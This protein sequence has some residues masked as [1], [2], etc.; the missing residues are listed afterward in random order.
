MTKRAL[1]AIVNKMI[2]RKLQSELGGKLSEETSKL[3]FKEISKLSDKTLLMQLFQNVTM[4]KTVKETR[5]KVSNLLIKKIMEDKLMIKNITEEVAEKISK[6]TTANITEIVTKNSVEKAISKSN[7]IIMKK[8]LKKVTEKVA[9]KT[10]KLAVKTTIVSAVNT[11]PLVGQVAGFLINAVFASVDLIQ[12]ILDREKKIANL[13]ETITNINKAKTSLNSIKTDLSLAKQS[14]SDII[15]IDTVLSETDSSIS[16]DMRFILDMTIDKITMIKQRVNE[17]TCYNICDSSIFIT[18]QNNFTASKNIITKSSEIYNLAYT[19]N[20]GLDL[21]TNLSDTTA[22]RNLLLKQRNDNGNGSLV[23]IRTKLSSLLVYYEAIYREPLPLLFHYDYKHYRQIAIWS[24][25]QKTTAKHYDEYLSSFPTSD[26][27]VRN[28]LYFLRSPSS[29]SHYRYFYSPYYYNDSYLWYNQGEISNMYYVKPLHYTTWAIIKSLLHL[30]RKIELLIANTDSVNAN[31]PNLFNKLYYGIQMVT[32]FSIADHSLLST[33]MK[34]TYNSSSLTSSYRYKMYRYIFNKTLN[35]FKSVNSIGT[36]A[37]DGS[38]Y[39]YDETNKVFY[40]LS[41]PDV[42]SLAYY[43]GSYYKVTASTGD[44]K[45][46][47]ELYTKHTNVEKDSTTFIT[48][49]SNNKTS[50]I[51]TIYQNDIET[52]CAID[53]VKYDIYYYTNDPPSNPTKAVNLN[54]NSKYLSI[55]QT[56]TGIIYFTAINNNNS[57]K[58]LCEKNNEDWY[59]VNS[60]N[61]Q[62]SNVICETTCNFILYHNNELYGLED[63]GLKLYKQNKTTKKL[64]TFVISLGSISLYPINFGV[65]NADINPYHF[66][67]GISALSTGNMD[68]KT[69]VN[70]YDYYLYK[71]H[72]NINIINTDIVDTEYGI[73]KNLAKKIHGKDSP[74][75]TLLT[76]LLDNV[77]V[78]G[79][80]IN[81]RDNSLTEDNIYI[82]VLEDNVERFSIT[83]ITLSGLSQNK[84]N[85]IFF[86]EK[87]KIILKN[88]NVDI[89]GNP[90]IQLEF[91]IDTIYSSEEIE[92]F[93]YTI[94][95]TLTRTTMSFESST[96]DIIHEMDFIDIFLLEVYIKN[97][98]NKSVSETYN[99]TQKSISTPTI[100]Y[101][102]YLSNEL[103]EDVINIKVK[104]KGVKNKKFFLSYSPIPNTYTLSNTYSTN[105]YTSSALSYSN[106]INVSGPIK[107]LFNTIF[108]KVYFNSIT[109]YKNGDIKFNDDDSSTFKLNDTIRNNNSLKISYS[110]LVTGST[111]KI[112]VVY[113]TNNTNICQAIFNE[114]QEKF[115]VISLTSSPIV[116][117]WTSFRKIC[118]YT[119]TSM[120]NSVDITPIINISND[121]Y[122]FIENASDFSVTI[123]LTRFNTNYTLYINEISQNWISTNVDNISLRSPDYPISVF[124]IPNKMNGITGLTKINPDNYNSI[125][126]FP[127]T[128]IVGPS[129]SSGAIVPVIDY[130]GIKYDKISLSSD[131]SLVAFGRNSQNINIKP[132]T[133]DNPTLPKILLGSNNTISG[134][135]GPLLNIDSNYYT[136]TISGP[137]GSSIYIVRYEEY[138]NRDYTQLLPVALISDHTQYPYKC[139]NSSYSSIQH[140]PYKCFNQIKGKTE[141]DNAGWRSKKNDYVSNN[142]FEAGLNTGSTIVSGMTI[143]GEWVEL[144]NIETQFAN[145]KEVVLYASSTLVNLR[146]PKRIMVCGSNDRIT[147]TKMLDSNELL[148]GPMNYTEGA[149]H[150][151]NSERLLINH[152]TNYKNIRLIVMQI[153]GAENPALL[154]IEYK[155]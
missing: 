106:P 5:E 51:C 120:T 45:Q 44:I 122:F 49:P 137:S 96:K 6:K 153:R 116:F 108:D 21:S 123:P 91:T 27:G 126:N 114:N 22:F 38:A 70:I 55:T 117:Y 64:D 58:Y 85:L 43:R 155:K 148:N 10:T 149:E 8:A 100:T 125:S 109:I 23:T 1:K 37:A 107:V 76:Q 115:T 139:F 110:I 145:I 142:N 97:P 67:I 69:L 104:F 39:V 28:L 128:G 143:I 20:V 140:M 135:Y 152:S 134:P 98:I 34:I 78:N 127:F 84:L 30:A 132:A 26:N 68:D 52:L 94:T 111:R 59:F 118:N 35:N 57:K 93:G 36:S 146:F 46:I 129:G 12:G 53:Y 29:L 151:T 19:I 141:D 13:N 42:K 63:T 11:L 41:Y 150:I 9:K 101:K 73:V 130:L 2:V 71:A 87:P 61:T 65:V 18:N 144:G 124:P 86:I 17:Y 32:A 138:C 62:K 81:Y 102:K 89:T 60:D 83:P 25:A 24:E 15:S 103:R 88:K 48:K 82:D 80:R 131:N 147:W 95:N 74:I 31:Y 113:N 14:I 112:V 54:T 3:I 121:K 133:K 47:N 56:P 99:F 72:Q 33:Q 75:A 7:T 154:E 79:S 90:K 66:E 136:G 50:S 16:D 92:N 119:L 4:K 105:P 77:P 40:N